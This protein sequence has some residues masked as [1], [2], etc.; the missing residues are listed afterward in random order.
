V[1]LVDL[2]GKPARV[3]DTVTVGQT[4]EG[5]KMSPDGRYVAVT[6]MNG[7][8][9]PKNSPFFNDNGLA[10]VFAVDGKKLSKVAEAKV[11]HWCQGAAWSKD[12]RT[13]LVQCMVE[14]EIQLLSFDGKELKAAGALKV[15]GGPAGIATAQR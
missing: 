8:N 9:K 10:V 5:A 3:V 7:S 13:L 1:S 6:A 15:K 12:G 2:Q 11:G 4:P 14:K